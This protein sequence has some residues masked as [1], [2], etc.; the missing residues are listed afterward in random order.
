MGIVVL[1]G[2]LVSVAWVIWFVVNK[3]RKIVI[4]S[5]SKKNISAMNKYLGTMEYFRLHKVQFSIGSNLITDQC[6]A[7]DF[8]NKLLCILQA[9][10]N[11]IKE[12]VYKY[13]VL[14]SSEIVENG[15][16]VIKASLSAAFITPELFGESGEIIGDLTLKNTPSNKA[17]EIGLIVIFNDTS[18]PIYK[19]NFMPYGGYGLSRNDSFYK[20]YKE[21]TRS[22]QDILTI[23]IQQNDD[24]RVIAN[25]WQVTQGHKL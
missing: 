5:N 22:W 25:G 2:I 3:I 20:K 10:N 7:I 15:Q 21:V 12:K 1:L 8:Q 13:E 24:E 6:L 19:F 11:F 14:N 16:S 4:I 23:I 17:N 18:H 9:Q